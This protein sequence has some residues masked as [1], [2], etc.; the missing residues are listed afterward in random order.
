[1]IASIKQ[2]ASKIAFGLMKYYSGNETY[3]TVGLLP[4]A[5]YWWEAGAVWG[6]MIDYWH[7]TN[8]TTYNS[9]VSQALL[10]QASSTRDFM[11][12]AQQSNEVQTS[13]YQVLVVYA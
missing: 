6:A 11:P 9:I 4:A 13:S 2:A 7:Y 12:V 3:G 5:Y 10:C 1:M 8:D